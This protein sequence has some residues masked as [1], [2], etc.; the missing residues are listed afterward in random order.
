MTI[1]VAKE[2][3][4]FL[5]E[6]NKNN[7]QQLALTLFG[8]EPTLNIPVIKTIMEYGE[9]LCNNYKR[10]LHLNMITNTT[11]FPDELYYLFKYYLKFYNFS[12]QMSVDGNEETQI[13]NRPS[14]DGRNLFNGILDN[15]YKY[16]KLFKDN[17][18]SLTIHGCLNKNSIRHLFDNYLFFKGLG[19]KSIW[20]CPIM[21]TDWTEEDVNIYYNEYEKIYKYI[22][23]NPNTVYNDI[24]EFA[25]FDKGLGSGT[26][27]P[28]RPCGMGIHYLAVSP[29]GDIYPCHQFYYGDKEENDSRL[30]DVY[31]GIDEY[32]KYIFSRYENSDLTGCQKSCTH[33]DKCYRCVAANYM[34]YGS[35]FSQITGNYCKLMKIDEF[36]QKLIKEELVINNVN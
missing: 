11:I 1:D 9:V 26:C 16:Q 33:S 29:N 25:P 5:F 4:K 19:L 3:L 18:R 13:K 23:R 24:L 21:N 36:F 20:F 28:V 12:V 17:P 22:T 34:E 2:T 35:M 31:E 6:T 30:G 32:K 7:N 14:R 10:N 8:G 15:I 27:N